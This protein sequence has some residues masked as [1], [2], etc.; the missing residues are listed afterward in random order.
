MMLLHPQ[1]R[2][3][4][5]PK[6]QVTAGGTKPVREP[7]G[8]VRFTGPWWNGDECRARSGAGRV[9]NATKL[10]SQ[11]QCKSGITL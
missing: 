1:R 4:E 6:A 5:H 7:G 9:G 10:S 8:S 11:S 3:Q 2:L